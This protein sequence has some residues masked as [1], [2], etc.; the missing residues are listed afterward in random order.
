MAKEHYEPMPDYDLGTP[1]FY[2][3]DKCV[4]FTWQTIVERN[5][6]KCKKH[7]L[8]VGWEY[9]LECENCKTRH[10]KTRLIVWPC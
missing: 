8:T 5:P 2:P 4:I 7:N 9:T 3:C 1:M 6:M 10:T